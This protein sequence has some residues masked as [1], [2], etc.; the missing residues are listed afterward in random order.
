VAVSELRFG[1]LY[2]L[3]AYVLWG[4][5]PVYFKLL[6]PSRPG[7]VLAHRVVWSALFMVLVL[8]AVRRWRQISALLRRPATMAGITLA[9]VLI[10]V[11]WGTFLY[12]LLVELVVYTLIV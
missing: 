9:A 5:F 12:E 6:E 1:Y 2:G 3:G 11:N 7:E 4:V 10:A 8:T